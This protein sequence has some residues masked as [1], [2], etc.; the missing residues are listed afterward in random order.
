MCSFPA[1]R[2]TKLQWAAEQPSTGG[3]WNSSKKDTPKT[4]KPQWDSRGVEITIKSNSIP[5]GWVIQNNSKE[6]LPLLWGSEPHVRVPSL[7]IWQRLIRNPKEF[8]SEGQWDLIKRLPQNWG[9]QRLQPWRAKTKTLHTSRLRGKEQW[10]FPAESKW[11]AS[12][13]GSPVQAWI[14]RGL[15]QGHGHRQDQAGKTPHPS[16]V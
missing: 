4:K 5:A 2:A 16:L 10:S 1:A 3:C 14:S 12:A 13:G 9:K 7:G 6:V 11:L 8:V 15:P